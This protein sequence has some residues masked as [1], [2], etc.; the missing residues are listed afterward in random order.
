M[1]SGSTIARLAPWLLQPE[2]PLAALVH[3]P[4]DAV[5]LAAIGMV[6][7][8]LR[9]E[10]QRAF[11]LH[12]FEQYLGGARVGLLLFSVLFGLGHYYQGWAAAIVTGLL[13]LSWGG[14][15]LWRRSIVAPVVSHAAFN[16]LETLVLVGA[17]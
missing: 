8:G 1:L 3:S 11:I 5:L 13:G 7:G 9:E 4:T 17:R 10:V 12:R 6:S 15:Y 2:N 14:V 16:L